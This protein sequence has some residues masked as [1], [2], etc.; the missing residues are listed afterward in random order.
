MASPG[1]SSGLYFVFVLK[2]SPQE[3][4]QFSQ[5]IPIEYHFPIGMSSDFVNFHRGDA[6]YEFFGSIG[7]GL[8][9]QS[10]QLGKGV[11]LG[12]IGILV[13]Y[14]EILAD[15]V[16]AEPT[17]LLGDTHGNAMGSLEDFRL[18]VLVGMP[19]T[20]LAYRLLR[21]LDILFQCASLF[22]Y[23]LMTSFCLR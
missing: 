18:T 8:F 14:L 21:K 1:V 13:R 11:L 20:E 10:L 22:W 9:Q 4:L 2:S 19:A 16:D 12:L 7:Q 15:K 3:L 23:A 17:L 6:V 5:S